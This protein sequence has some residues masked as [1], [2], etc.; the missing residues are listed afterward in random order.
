[1][2]ALC[3]V[4]KSKGWGICDLL[5]YDVGSDRVKWEDGAEWT[6]F[7]NGSGNYTDVIERNFAEAEKK[8]ILFSLES[9]QDKKERLMELVN[10]EGSWGRR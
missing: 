5:W 9:T 8:I 6:D 7:A 3:D 4:D 1:M 2:F 10:R